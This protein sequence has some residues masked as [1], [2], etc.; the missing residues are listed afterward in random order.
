MEGL[1][2][3]SCECYAAVRMQCDRLLNATG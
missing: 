2:K 3:T 1:R